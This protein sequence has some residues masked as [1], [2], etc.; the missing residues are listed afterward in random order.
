MGEGDN[1]P[2]GRGLLDHLIELIKADYPDDWV[3]FCHLARLIE[4]DTSDDEAARRRLQVYRRYDIAG[5]SP[6]LGREVS[7][8]NEFRKKF[9]EHFADVYRDHTWI[10]RAQGTLETRRLEPRQIRA[11]AL[12]FDPDELVLDKGKLVIV[13]ARIEPAPAKPEDGAIAA[14]SVEEAPAG[15]AETESTQYKREPVI[16]VLKRLFPP[17]GLRPKGRSVK[18]VTNSLNK[19]PEFKDK[20]VSEETVYRAFKDMEAALEK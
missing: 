7:A 8:S 6:S 2:L 19:L 12:R 16:L 13:D 5:F 1:T 9:V 3:R 14:A 15:A 17:D 18:W 4:R 20:P 10:G 11:G